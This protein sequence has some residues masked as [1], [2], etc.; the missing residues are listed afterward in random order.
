MTISGDTSTKIAAPGKIRFSLR[1]GY[2]RVRFC[3]HGWK[4][5][6]RKRR[7]KERQA[8]LNKGTAYAERYDL[9]FDRCALPR[10]YLINTSRLLFDAFFH[11]ADDHDHFART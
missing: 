4:F 3:R 9:R 6:H 8:C 11:G 7:L 10:T 5:Y 2:G 1:W